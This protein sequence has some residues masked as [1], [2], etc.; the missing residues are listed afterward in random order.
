MKES[1]F[2]LSITMLAVTVAVLNSFFVSHYIFR[3]RTAI[4]FY[5]I[6]YWAKLRRVEGA[7]Q[8]VQEDIMRFTIALE[9]W[10]VGLIK[11][12]IILLAF[13]PILVQLSEKVSVLPI[14]G[15]NQILVGLGS[16]R[17][18]AFWDNVINRCRS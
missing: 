11:A 17:M 7:A 4:N 16:H 13:L 18:G 8:R 1:L 12:I 9:T 15:E 14:V 6:S 3:W 2:L 5:Y 10:G